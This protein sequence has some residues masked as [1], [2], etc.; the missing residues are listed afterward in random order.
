MLKKSWM[1]GFLILG[2]LVMTTVAIS[3]SA[4]IARNFYVGRNLGTAVPVSSN[5]VLPIALSGTTPAKITVAL[6]LQALAALF[7]LS[8]AAL[9]MRGETSAGGR[10]SAIA[11]MLVGL[12]LVTLWASGLR[13]SPQPQFLPSEAVSV[14]VIPVLTCFVVAAIALVVR[15]RRT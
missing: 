5:T 11:I 7:V 4:L 15:P 10:S 6:L 3:L 13:P 14:V 2:F 1:S 12:W 8:L 9:K